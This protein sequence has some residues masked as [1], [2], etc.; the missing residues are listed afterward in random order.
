MN[1]IALYDSPPFVEANLFVLVHLLGACALGAL[2]GY[3]RSFHGRAA[4]MRTYALVC[5]ASTGLTVILGYPEFWYGGKFAYTGGGGDPTRVIQGIVTGIGFLGAGMIVREG[6][7]IKG[8]STAASIWV[9]SA[10]GVILG[11]GFH[12]AAAVAAVMTVALLSGMHWIER[13][14]PRQTLIHLN[15]RFSRDSTPAD[16]DLQSMAERHGFVVL[17]TSYRLGN[18]GGYFE[19]QLALRSYG[20]GQSSQLAHELAATPEVIEFRLSPQRE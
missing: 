12:L 17:E 3:E 4:G 18:A 14:L 1:L 19:F 15:V 16:E 5:L 9:T 20:K 13:R 7:T 11:L 2:I 8:L 6:L 10:V